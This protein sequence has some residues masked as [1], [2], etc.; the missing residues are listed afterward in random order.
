VEMVPLALVLGAWEAYTL[1]ALPE[2]VLRPTQDQ[3]S[4]DRHLH[5]RKE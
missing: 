5:N 1:L 2:L 4:D 3:Q